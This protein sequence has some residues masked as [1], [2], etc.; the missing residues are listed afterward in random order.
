MIKN[1][2]IIDNSEKLEKTI[3]RIWTRNVFFMW[4]YAVFFTATIIRASFNRIFQIPRLIHNFWYDDSRVYTRKISKYKWLEDWNIL[5]DSNYWNLWIMFLFFFI[6]ALSKTLYHM[7]KILFFL[8]KHIFKP[9][10]WMLVVL[11][12][13]KTISDGLGGKNNL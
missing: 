6:I 7:G 8:W 4:W 13:A 1:I 9:L 5:V 2:E 11:M 3:K 12:A 10:L